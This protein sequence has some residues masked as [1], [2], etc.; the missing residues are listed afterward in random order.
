MFQA[1][2]DSVELTEDYLICTRRVEDG[3]KSIAVISI[4]DVSE[5]LRTKGS[6]TMEIEKVFSL[7]HPLEYDSFA[8]QRAL[9]S[10]CTYH[11]R[12]KAM[13]DKMSITVT[14]DVRMTFVREGVFIAHF[15]LIKGEHPSLELLNSGM[16]KFASTD[17]RVV[18]EDRLMS[19]L[20]GWYSPCHV[21]I[22][23]HNIDSPDENDILKL[24]SLSL[25]HDMTLET[26]DLDVDSVVPL[27]IR[28]EFYTGS[29]VYATKNYDS[30]VVKLA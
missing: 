13:R 27:S 7:E 10:L 18:V 25:R 8:G 19:I 1:A 26:S 22:V 3:K 16:W 11:W 29:L 30:A 15:S 17:N 12:P 21:P 2:L 28:S 4:E 20:P 14:A 6:S 9:L 24:A 23:F 5:R